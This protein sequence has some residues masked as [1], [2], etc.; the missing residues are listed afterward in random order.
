M[1]C[2]PHKCIIEPPKRLEIGSE[3]Q[4]VINDRRE[5][6]N[7]KRPEAIALPR[8]I[9]YRHENHHEHVHSE[10]PDGYE[11]HLGSNFHRFGT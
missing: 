1:N 6:K 5:Y 9:R 3:E 10:K 11:S 7:P 2:Q 4:Q 8:G